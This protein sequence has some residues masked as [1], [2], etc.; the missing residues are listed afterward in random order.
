M[1]QLLSILA[2]CGLLAIMAAP[3]FG[4]WIV[5]DLGT[6]NPAGSSDATGI[7]DNGAYVSGW[8]TLSD[9][10]A[11]PFRF[12]DANRNLLVDPDEIILGV[13]RSCQMT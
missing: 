4:A 1:R 8:T 12:K 13:L 6:L 7:S 10:T 5:V 2:I 9:G 3:G 11:A